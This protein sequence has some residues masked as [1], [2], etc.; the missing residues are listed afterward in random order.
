MELIPQ[1]METTTAGGWRPGSRVNL[2]LDLLGKYVTA[3]APG[4]GGG[5]KDYLSR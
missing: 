1:T 2:E 5:L 4:R 3:M